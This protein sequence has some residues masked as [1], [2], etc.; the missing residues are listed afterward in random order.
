MWSDFA[1]SGIFYAVAGITVLFALLSVT[2]KNIFHSALSLIV[3]LL[4]VA[5]VY[6][7]LDAEFLALLQVLIYVGAIMTLIIFGIMMTLKISDKSLRQH[8]RQKFLSFL[9]SGAMAALL[10]SIF[11]RSNFK[12]AC[13]IQ[14][15][16]SLQDIGRLLLTKYA[17][18][19][20]IISVILL[21]ALIGAV[22]I[23]RKD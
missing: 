14:P 18:P 8:N 2:L 4:G 12:K 15:Q 22:V 10:I 6:I 5:A 3:A 13:A 21:A 23:S 9:I 1:S 20:E 19:F 7:Y 11:V 16:V 17:L